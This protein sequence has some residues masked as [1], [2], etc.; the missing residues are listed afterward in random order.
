MLFAL[1]VQTS[2]S[3]LN[4]ITDNVGGVSVPSLIEP[5]AFSDGALVAVTRMVW[6]TCSFSFSVFPVS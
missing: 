6:P 4:E 1:F 2:E 5:G 3:R